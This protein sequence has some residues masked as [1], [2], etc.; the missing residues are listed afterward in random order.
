M[1]LGRFP[2]GKT[3]LS[4]EIKN[5]WLKAINLVNW[6]PQSK[7][8]V[9]SEHFDESCLLFRSDGVRYLKKNVIPTI[10]PP[11]IQSTSTKIINMKEVKSE[12]ILHD[13]DTIE[14]NNSIIDDGEIHY[15]DHE[16]ASSSSPPPPIVSLVL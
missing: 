16:M 7:D 5:A 15:H 1:C 10:F 6:E 12:I 4:L 13:N 2:S 8:F 11:K 9:C 14:M 3:A